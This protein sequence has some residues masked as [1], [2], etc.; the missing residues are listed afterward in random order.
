MRVLVCSIPLLGH[1]NPL[2]PLSWAL[3][4]EGHEVLVATDES[5][6]PRVLERGLPV[7]SLSPVELREVMARDRAGR[8]VPHTA[9]AD[10]M[11]RSGRG[12]GR[13]GARHLAETI[14]LMRRWGP[15][16]VVTDPVEFAGPLAAARLGI[17]WIE[18]GWGIRPSPEFALA[19]EEELEP[20][21]G[22]F[23]LTG[24]PRPARVLDTCSPSLQRPGTF[25]DPM[26]YISVTGPAELP[27]WLDEPR[28]RPLV[29]LTFGSVLPSLAPDRMRTLITRL[30]HTLPA[31]DVEVVV[32]IDPAGAQGLR[33]APPG[34]LSVGWQ[35]LD[36]VVPRC[37]VLVHYGASGMTM[38]AMAAGVP[39]VVLTVPIADAP[40]N[41]RR[42]E[43]SGLGIALPA[44]DLDAERVVAA[45]RA[46]LA[47]PSWR[48]RAAEVAAEQDYR[49]APAEVAA[50]F[51]AAFG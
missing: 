13:L 21:L 9:E 34:V 35:P 15:D 22:A 18:H 50:G 27:G 17:P 48:V 36:H 46:L 31:L 14:A 43:A 25:G 24:L 4:A 3:R 30:M 41:A 40:D 19:A 38:A 26:R 44:L 20:E 39:Q 42:I 8:P 32:A 29:C 37:A 7:A 5:F 11:W 6:A 33:P 23:G 47:E 45:C 2:L 16:L 51:T 28:R 1:L 10:R 49:P 12:W